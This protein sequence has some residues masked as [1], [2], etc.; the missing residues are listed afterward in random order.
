VPERDTGENVPGGHG[1]HAT[2]P[3][4][5]YAP[6][7]QPNCVADVE[8][9][10][11][12][13]PAVHKP[14]HAAVVRPAVLPCTPAGH[15]V[16]PVAL[17][18]LYVPS[19]HNVG[20]ADVD[21]HAAP[22]GHAVYAAEPAALQNPAGVCT[23]DDAPVPPGVPRYVPAGHAAAVAFVEPATQK[24]PGSQKPAHAGVGK[25]ATFP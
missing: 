8:P 15:D 11:Q 21:G 23:H 17:P 5:L 13:E 16:Q 2:A 10:E 7:A 18:T 6:A 1:E 25:P 20:G 9:V 24:K 3:A 12:N 19:A 4:S 22:A 14:E